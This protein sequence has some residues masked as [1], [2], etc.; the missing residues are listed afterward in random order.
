VCY[1][2]VIGIRNVMCREI[3]LLHT[4][5]TACTRCCICKIIIHIITD[6]LFKIRIAITTVWL[7]ILYI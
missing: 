3:V 7:C 4:E 5:Q 6:E 2:Y 1:E